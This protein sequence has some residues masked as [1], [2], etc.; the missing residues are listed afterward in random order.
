MKYELFESVEQMLAPETMSEL[1]GKSIRYVR[2]NPMEKQGASGSQLMAVEAESNPTKEHY[3]LKRLSRSIDWMMVAGEDHLCRSVTLWQSGLLDK[4]QPKIDHAI[5]ACARDGDGWAILMR[6]V[7]ESLI[8]APHYPLTQVHI[9]IEALS[10]LHA[11]FWQHPALQDHNIGLGDIGSML[12]AFSPRTARR[13]QNIPGLPDKWSNWI[14]DSKALLLEMVSLDVADALIELQNNLQSLIKVL[15]S[16]PYTLLHGDY[17][18]HNL[19]LSS[20]GKTKI[21]LLD[22]GLTGYG[23]PMVDLGWFVDGV[24][25]RS[26]LLPN[27]AIDYYRQC[28][29]KRLDRPFEDQDWQHWQ[30]L[31]RLTHILRLGFVM[32]WLSENCEMEEERPIFRRIVDG[33][34]DQVRAALKWL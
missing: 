4:L 3:V 31:G 2:Y 24:V 33:Y 15:E 11:T 14:I 22:W 18:G 13:Y 34:N 6:D 26:D 32:A 30:E 8:Q 7:S 12:R 17:G 1:S 10:A 23:L 21:Y 27:A 5:L 28:L 16:G 25:S 19:G 29:E 9:A 20:N